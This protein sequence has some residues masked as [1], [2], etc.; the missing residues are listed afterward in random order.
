MSL[1]L[2]DRVFSTTLY[3]VFLSSMLPDQRLGISPLVSE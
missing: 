1:G 3:L 2:S